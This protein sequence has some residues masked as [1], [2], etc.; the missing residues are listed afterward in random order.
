MAVTPASVSFDALGAT[1]QLSATVL[2][3]NGSAMTGAS[4]SWTTSDPAAAT[5]SSAGLVTTV[6]NGAAT[7]TAT[8]G[9]V[10][11]TSSVTVAQTPVSVS[12][13]P[14]SLTLGGPGAS[15]TVVA[16]AYDAGGSEVQGATFS[17]TSSE[18]ATA[19]VDES[20]LVT[21]VAA[22]TVDLTAEASANGGTASGVLPLIV[23]PSLEIATTSLGDGDQYLPYASMLEATGGGGVYTWTLTAGALPS[24]VTLLSSGEL[25]GT[26]PVDGDFVF[27]ASVSSDDGQTAARELTLTVVRAPTL[28]PAELCS[29]AP[30]NAIASFA[31]ANLESVV[32][33]A[34][35]LGPSDDLLC[36]LAP[37]LRD[38]D[39]ENQGITDLTGIQNFTSLETVLLAVNAITDVAPLSGLSALTI[40]DLDT[41]QI[42]DVSPLAGLTGLEGLN[43]NTNQIADVAPL[44]ALS[45]LRDLSLSGYPGSIAPLA[46][47]SNLE[48]LYMR[49]NQ[50]ADLN[51][52]SSWPKLIWLDVAGAH[53]ISD[54]SPLS[55]LSSLTS[56]DVTHYNGTGAV[57]DLTPIAGLTGLTYLSVGGHAITD[58]GP[59]EGLTNLGFLYLGHSA[60]LSD[61]QPLIDN[62]GLGA[63]DEVDLRNLAPALRCSDVAQLAGRG[64]TVTTGL[65]FADANL[66]AVV[67]SAAGLGANDLLSCSAAGAL[68]TLVAEFLSI[69]DIDGIQNLTGLVDLQLDNNALTDIGQLNGLTGLIALA[70]EGN[71]ISDLGPLSALTSLD[72]LTLEA[73]AITDVGPLSGL[74]SLRVLGLS[75]NSIT[76]VG[77]L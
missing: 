32:R 9:T 60:G 70:L 36:S 35:G 62:T 17:W 41:N 75:E 26:P 34:L 30:A 59:L 6:A 52:V 53:T 50:L 11:S 47:L 58:L 42:T 69:T 61:I 31:D 3:Q 19:T 55:G 37:D 14:A 4:V 57:S 46:A 16:T 38:F 54:L 10:S 24:G 23:N 12:L 5:V 18:P 1:Q 63:G 2:D 48:G 73:N 67:R 77:P 15:A 40:L 20:G 71:A 13:D 21:A 8:S 45:G 56:L 76:D 25:E 72:Q 65:T 39:A 66:N 64:V 7:I 43:L 22:G 27:T 74:T 44:A 33:T 49:T 68:T 29:A 28:A 51:V